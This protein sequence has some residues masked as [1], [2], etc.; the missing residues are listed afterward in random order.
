M[1]YDFVLFVRM[2][3]CV[4]WH[5]LIHGIVLYVPGMHIDS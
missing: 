2:I 5:F 4:L 1:N 3:A